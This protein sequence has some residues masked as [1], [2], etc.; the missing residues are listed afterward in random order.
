MKWSYGEVLGGK[1]VPCTL[2]LQ[3]HDELKKIA[4]DIL[5]FNFT[6]F[7]QNTLFMCIRQLEF[8]LLQLTQQIDKLFNFIRGLEL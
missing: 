6:L 5:W 2:G 4:K 3:S 7:G 1:K 8:G